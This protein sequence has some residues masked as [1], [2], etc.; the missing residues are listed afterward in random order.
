MRTGTHQ[1]VLVGPQVLPDLRGVQGCLDLTQN[2]QT[3]I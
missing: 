3:L 1:E 2:P